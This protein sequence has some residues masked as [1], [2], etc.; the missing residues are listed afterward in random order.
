MFQFH[1]VQF[2]G[3][4][5]KL[6]KT[7][8]IS[9]NSIRYNFGKWDWLDLLATLMFQFH[10]VQFWGNDDK[11]VALII[12]VSIPY[13]TILGISAII[14]NPLSIIVSIPY[15]TILGK[16]ETTVNINEQSFNSI[17]YNFG[18]GCTAPGNGKQSF[19][20]HTVQF[21][22]SNSCHWRYTQ[23]V[24]I[25]YGTILGP[26]RVA[27]WTLLF[28]FNSIRYNFGGKKI[29][30]IRAE[31]V[32]FN[33][34][35]YNF[36]KE[37]LESIK[38]WPCFN[39]IRYNF[40]T[41]FTA[42]SGKD[43][44]F[45]FHTVQFWEYGGRASRI[46]SVAFQFHTVQFWVCHL[47]MSADDTSVSIPYGTILGSSNRQGSNACGW[48]QFHTVQFWAYKELKELLPKVLFQFH[49]VQFW[50]GVGSGG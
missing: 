24:S 14:S 18:S 23:T 9:F 35:R 6:L 7:Y 3:I 20:F 19:Q 4:K 46:G 47:R 33:S 5:Y 13:G 10:T 50:A 49:T 26:F 22:A 43:S 8:P 34:I 15:G 38:D 21:W 16:H 41:Q 17:R 2:W 40:G 45:Q 42:N 37:F 30:R 25:P 29:G 44:S 28:C 27:L 1:T 11:R 39:S 12:N 36:G 32:S 48:F 31:Y